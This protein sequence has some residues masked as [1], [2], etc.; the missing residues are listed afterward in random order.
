MGA[1]AWATTAQCGTA[2]QNM[3]QLNLKEQNIAQQEMLWSYSMILHN[4]TISHALRTIRSVK[5]TLIA[6]AI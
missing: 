4:V 2:S 1:L 3:T 5:Q 6:Y